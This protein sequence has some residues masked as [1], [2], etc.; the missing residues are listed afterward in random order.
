MHYNL[1]YCHAAVENGGRRRPDRDAPAGA[2]YVMPLIPM[3]MYEV[4]YLRDSMS[5]SAINTH[6]M[7]RSAF[8]ALYCVSD[9]FYD[10]E[11]PGGSG[12]TSKRPGRR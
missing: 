2:E 9:T 12:F 6:S 3:R 8:Y 7:T 1:V 10:S 11:R 5:S 4:Q